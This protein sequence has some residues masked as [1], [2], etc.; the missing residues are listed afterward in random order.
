M[1]SVIVPTYNEAQNIASLLTRLEAVRSQL[2]ESLEVLIVDGGSSDGT[3]QMARRLLSAAGL[4]QLIAWTGP[5]DLAQAVREGMRRAQGDIW[6]VM[7]ADLSHPPELIPA[8]A[9]AV[10]D[11]CDVSVA[12]RY[13]AGG[14]TTGWSWHRRGLSWLGNLA[15]RPLTTVRDATSGY[16]A[17]RA[18]VVRGLSWNP[19]GFKILLE[20]LVA[21]RVTRVREVPYVFQDRRFGSSKL[22]AR[23]CGRYL[24]RLMRLYAARWRA[25]V[26][27][28]VPG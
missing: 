25:R 5:A 26:V 15:A 16:F 11:G 20:L 17:C 7:D 2:R 19:V 28:G 13:V 3:A 14:G 10:R 8:L 23:V 18:D 22:G 21:A 1:L 6:V 4:G 12:S 24:A 9:Q 27:A